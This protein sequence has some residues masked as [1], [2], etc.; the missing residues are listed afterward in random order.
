METVF[1]K[2]FN[3]GFC[4]LTSSSIDELGIFDLRRD[5][6]CAAGFLHD[7]VSVYRLRSGDRV[8]G[9]DSRNPSER[10]FEFLAYRSIYCQ[11]FP[12]NPALT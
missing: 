3:S 9:D 4:D 10:S 5:V 11:G 8:A 12:Q 2:Q 7:S 1:Y 6:S